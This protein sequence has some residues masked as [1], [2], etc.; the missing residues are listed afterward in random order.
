MAAVPDR[1]ATQLLRVARDPASG[2]LHNPG[3]LASGLRAALFTDLILTGRV[4]EAGRG[5]YADEPADSGDRILDAV[6]RAVARRPDVAW[7]RWFRHVRV[8][9]VALVDELVQAGR[10]TAHHGGRGAAYEDRDADEA[11][12]RA[13]TL[14]RVVAGELA[15]ADS[16]QAVLAMLTVMCGSIDQRPHPRSVRLRASRDGGGPALLRRHWHPLIEAAARTGE[17]GADVQPEMLFGASRLLKRP[18]RRG[19]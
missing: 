9:R 3:P 6:Q 17:P 11:L 15:P 10:W 12:A 16:R 13:E 14:R 2:R 5:P 18:L 8:D 7:W 1:L 19:G 4:R